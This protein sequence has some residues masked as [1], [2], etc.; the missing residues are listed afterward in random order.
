MQYCSQKWQ[1]E[2][3]TPKLPENF[4][5]P[6]MY[7]PPPTVVDSPDTVSTFLKTYA[8]PIKIFHQDSSQAQE[9]CEEFADSIRAGRHLVPLLNSDG[10]LAGGFIRIKQAQVQAVDDTSALLTLTWDSRYEYDRGTYDKMG[11]LYLTENLS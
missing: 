9:K 7:F 1:V 11:A 5:I 4:I 8:L 2:I 6:S 3:Y 10:S